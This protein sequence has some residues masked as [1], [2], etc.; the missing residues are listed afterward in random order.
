MRSLGT[1]VHA[2]SAEAHRISRQRNHVCVIS[3]DTMRVCTD[4]RTQTW[5]TERWN[6]HVSP[7]GGSSSWLPL[8]A[9]RLHAWIKKAAKGLWPRHY[10]SHGN[11]QLDWT[12]LHL[13]LSLL[14]LCSSS[15]YR[16]IFFNRKSC[17]FVSFYSFLRSSAILW[18]AT[19]TDIRNIC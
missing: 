2:V 6:Q 12:L 11:S 9:E 1:K 18:R 13:N 16:C 17:C 4:F 8:C 3:E 7:E 15:Q 19:L 10:D 5:G 14:P